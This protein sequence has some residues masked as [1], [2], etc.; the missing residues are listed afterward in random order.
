ML[1]LLAP[2]VSLVQCFLITSEFIGLF[3]PDV[4][5]LAERRSRRCEVPTV[6]IK[7]ASL[8][9][10]LICLLLKVQTLFILPGSSLL[11]PESPRGSGL[12]MACVVLQ[13]IDQINVHSGNRGPCGGP[14]RSKRK[15]NVC[16]DDCLN[17][18][19]FLSQEELGKGG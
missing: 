1:F 9:S 10:A 13:V 11:A 12:A 19:I 4:A 7:I 3:Q 15:V 6:F 17:T 5:T 2:S 14:G 18:E 16:K 8:A